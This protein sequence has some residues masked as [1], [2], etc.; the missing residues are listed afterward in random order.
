[1]WRLEP[2]Q[3]TPAEIVLLKGKL[4]DIELPVKEVDII[5]SEVRVPLFT[6]R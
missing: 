4:E 5:I 1:M 2:Y 3:L 6:T